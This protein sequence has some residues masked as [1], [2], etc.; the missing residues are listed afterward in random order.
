[1]RRQPDRHQERLPGGP[2]VRWVGRSRGQPAWRPWS[3][4]PRS[5]GRACLAIRPWAIQ[6]GPRPSQSF[7]STDP[8]SADA[9]HPAAPGRPSGCQLLPRQNR[10]QA[11][12]AR[13][14]GLDPAAVRPGSTINPGT[15]RAADRGAE[16]RLIGPAFPFARALRPLAAAQVAGPLLADGLSGLRGQSIWFCF[17]GLPTCCWR[18]RVRTGGRPGACASVPRPPA[19]AF[20]SG[21]LAWGPSK[22]LICEADPATKDPLG[23]IGDITQRWIWAWPHWCQ[24]QSEPPS[25]EG[26]PRPQPARP[27]AALAGQREATCQ[28]RCLIHNLPGQRSA[29]R[30][31][32]WPGALSPCCCRPI[33]R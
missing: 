16:R 30:T 22:L 24:S 7:R 21:W 27:A 15:N 13:V 33:G 14:T 20:S 26:Q 12:M 9:G 19:G 1:M 18:R 23:T 6:A 8:C 17:A 4:S 29:E 28:A 25:G 5:D 32:P 11:R 10:G 31:R 2:A 3:G